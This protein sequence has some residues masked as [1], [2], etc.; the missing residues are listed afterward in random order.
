MPRNKGK[1][2]P[3]P[4]KH[5]HKHKTQKHKGLIVKSIPV[6]KHLQGLPTWRDTWKMWGIRQFPRKKHNLKTQS[7]LTNLQHLLYIILLSFIF[8]LTF[9]N[10][11]YTI[12]SDKP[13]FHNFIGKLDGKLYILVIPSSGNT[14]NSLY[15]L[16]NLSIIRKLKLEFLLCN[17]RFGIRRSTALP[18]CSM[19]FALEY[20]GFEQERAT[21]P[22]IPPRPA[23]PRH[24]A[25]PRL[26]PWCAK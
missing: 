13:K 18:D 23:P 22:A 12:F 17:R 24:P 16:N 2:Q 4:Q 20:S 3:Q 11:E 26:H 1:P 21:R 19:Y 9:V 6:K 14:R 5:K 25:P 10:H 8:R 7:S 15:C